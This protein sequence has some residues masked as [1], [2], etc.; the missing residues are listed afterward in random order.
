MKALGM[1]KLRV[2]LSGL[3]GAPIQ[4]EA[5]HTIAARVLAR[6]DARAAE[7]RQPFGSK[8]A[9]AAPSAAASDESS[10]PR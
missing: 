6:L 4:V 7:H 10:P 9:P 1:N 3:G 2:E 5:Q 8:N